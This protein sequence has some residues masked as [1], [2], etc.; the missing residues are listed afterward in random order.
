MLL[1][2]LLLFT[3]SAGQQLGR[4]RLQEYL[5]EN[6]WK[7][8]ERTDDPLPKRIKIGASSSAFKI[9]VRLSILLAN[10]LDKF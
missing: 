1:A 6:H 3:V 8:D 4:E 2:S 7:R 5:S 10:L 9:E